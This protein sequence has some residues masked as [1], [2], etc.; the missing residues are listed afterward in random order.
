MRIRKKK[1]G[2]ARLEACSDLLIKSPDD[3]ESYRDKMQCELEIGCGKGTYICLTA[4]RNP[5][6]FYFAAELV[7]DVL[8]TALERAKNLKVENLRFLNINATE[9]PE[10]FREKEVDVIHLNFSDPWP[11]AR[12]AKR[13][14]THRNFL[15]MYK[16]IL[17]DDGKILFKTDNRQLFDFSLGEFTAAGLKVTDVTYDLHNSIYS[18]DNIQTEYE[19]NFSSKGFAINRAVASK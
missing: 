13:R 12:H 8:I 16:K 9:L 3:M 11:K 19:V 5:D 10:Y 14:L 15:E 1:N 18:E 17:S 6:K 2:Q 4:L 7:T